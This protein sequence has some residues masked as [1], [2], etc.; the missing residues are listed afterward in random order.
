M[1]LGG[2]GRGYDA[3][4]QQFWLVA[5]GVFGFA[6]SV[7]RATYIDGPCRKMDN[8]LQDTVGS[9]PSGNHRGRRGTRGR[10]EYANSV[11]GA[12]RFSRQ[13]PPGLGAGGAGGALKAWEF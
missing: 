3:Y 11:L 10:R 5:L 1:L 2:L 6:S 7:A 8:T 12:P 13:L 9:D 4:P